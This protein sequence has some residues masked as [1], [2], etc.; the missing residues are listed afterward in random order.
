MTVHYRTQ[1]FILE[2]TDL[3]EAD[4]VFTIYAKDFGKLKILG[5]AIR[6]IKSKLRPGAE[7]FY[8]SE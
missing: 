1:S 7:L 6:K 5:K 4:Q 8:L 2:K 3:R